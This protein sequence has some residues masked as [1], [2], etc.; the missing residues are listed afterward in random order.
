MT[1]TIQCHSCWKHLP[2][3]LAFCSCGVCLRPDQSNNKKDQ[4]EIPS[5]DSTLLCCSNKS[6]KGQ[7]AWRNSVATRLLE[8]NGCQKRSKETWLGYYHNLVATAWEVQK[9]SASPWMDGRI[10]PILALP[11][12]DRHLLH[13]TLASEAPVRERHHVG[14][15][16]WGS[17][18]WTMKARRELRPTTKILASLRQELGRQNSFIPK[19]A[20]TIRWSTASRVRMDESQ[21]EDLFLA[22]SFVIFTK[23]VATRTSILSMAWTPRH[24]MARSPMERSKMVNS[25]IF[26]RSVAYRKWRF[27]CK[28]LAV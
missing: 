19:N 5:F 4:S 23:L 20:K 10:L 17:S 3:G 21:L 26:P 22:T 15:Q 24:S 13:R 16:R 11:H 7:E 6:I 1:R 2:D 18:S 28:R 12:D 27:P 25:Q 9:F 8:S 14:M